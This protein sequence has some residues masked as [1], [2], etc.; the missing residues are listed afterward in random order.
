MLCRAILHDETRY[1]DPDVFNP[2]RFLTSDG[3]LDQNV[4]DPV[5]AFG[6]GR[7]I[8]PGRYFA[9]DLLFLNISSILAAF[10]LEKPVDQL[11]NVIEPKVEFTS[12]AFRR[13][14]CESSSVSVLLSNIQLRHAFQS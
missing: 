8:C 5:E 14:I 2:T 11:G 4:P 7:R 9:E 10:T 6:Y 13:V 1:P 12:G 3:K